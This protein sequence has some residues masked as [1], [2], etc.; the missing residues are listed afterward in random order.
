[1]GVGLF[2]LCF[3]PELVLDSV[4]LQRATERLSTIFCICCLADELASGQEISLLSDSVVLC[5][6]RRVLRL[7]L[8]ELCCIVVE[9]PLVGRDGRKSDFYIG[10]HFKW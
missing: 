7:G 10:N 4:G 5:W 9:P 1:M 8:R 3:S 6:R 2:G